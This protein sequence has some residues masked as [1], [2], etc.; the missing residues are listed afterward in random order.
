MY[1]NLFKHT[2]YKTICVFIPCVLFHLFNQLNTCNDNMKKED[3]A[4]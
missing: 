1:A 3:T 2:F 4:N